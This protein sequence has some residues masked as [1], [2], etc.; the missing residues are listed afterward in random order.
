MTPDFHG[1]MAA[2]VERNLRFGNRK[3][4]ILAPRVVYKTSLLTIA[5]SLWLV[6]NNPEVRVL[7]VQASAE[8]VKEVM[9]DLKKTITAWAFSHYFPE[10]MPGSGDR[11]SEKG[12]ELPRHGI[13]PEPTISARGVDSVITGGHYDVHIFDDVVDE[14]TAFSETDMERVIRWFKNSSPLFV[15]R[16]EGIRIVVGTRWAMQD[17][18]QY[19]IDRGGHETWIIGPYLDDPARRLGFSGDDGDLLFPEGLGHETIAGYLEDMEDIFFSYQILNKPV[20]EGLLRFRPDGIK[21]YNWVE[22]GHLL[23]A[24]AVQYNVGNLFRTMCIDPSLG[25]TAESDEFAVTIFGWDRV[26]ARGFLLGLSHGRIDP[27]LQAIKIMELH[28]KWKPHKTGIEHAGYQLALKSFTEEFMRQQ[29]YF[30][31]ID[32]LKPKQGAG[33]SNKSTRIEGLQPYVMNGQIYFTRDQ[34]PLIKQ[35]LGFQPRPDGSTGLKHDDLIDSASMHVPFW[36]GKHGQAKPEYADD[37]DIEDWTDRGGGQ[38]VASY[39]LQGET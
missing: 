28:K 31:W 17:L 19:I 34:G 36:Q 18:Y 15:R 20:V 16:N 35:M 2:W 37:D 23:V 39:G 30:F 12:I 25:R 5:M 8:K 10:L 32:P 38:R 7:I 4:M 27:R 22:Y 13:Y 29:N 3:M 1:R 24:D 11:F 9:N 21:Y 33:K 26:T 6:I 14:T